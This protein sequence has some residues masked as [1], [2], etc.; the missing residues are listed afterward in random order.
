[1]APPT[2]RLSIAPHRDRWFA[3]GALA[4]RRR[5]SLQRGLLSLRTG[6]SVWSLGYFSDP[7]VS[8][9]RYF[10]FTCLAEM[11]LCFVA[12]FTVSYAAANSLRTA[13]SCDRASCSDFSSFLHVGD[14]SHVFCFLQSRV[15]LLAEA[16][17]ECLHFC[18][19]LSV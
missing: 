8:F 18:S 15:S 12:C 2:T 10:S 9:S 13:I 17:S 6:I 7:S 14:R 16:V 1:M 11:S 4:R 19:C 5:T 3:V